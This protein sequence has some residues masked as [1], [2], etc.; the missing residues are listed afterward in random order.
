M[1]NVFSLGCSTN[2]TFPFYRSLR[3][4]YEKPVPVRNRVDEKK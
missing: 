2:Q 3:S 4:C 1:T